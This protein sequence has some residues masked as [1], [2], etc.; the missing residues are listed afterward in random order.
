MTKK[1]YA[2]YET[3]V[4]AFFT[5]E[6]ITNLARVDNAEDFYF[7][8]RPCDCCGLLDGARITAYG[9]NPK[10]KQVRSYAICIACEYYCEY[11]QLDDMTML[12]MYK[13]E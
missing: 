8:G 13:G 3:A 7:S 12:D 4:Q 1:E 9:F 5:Q 2:E 11:G 6:G 10:Y